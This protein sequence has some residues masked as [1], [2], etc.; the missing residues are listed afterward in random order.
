MIH[1]YSAN[2]NF[3]WY[4]KPFSFRWWIKVFTHYEYPE[5]PFN[6]TFTHVSIGEDITL[7]G[8]RL[9]FESFVVQM[10]N[11]Y[12]EPDLTAHFVSNHNRITDREL[13]WGIVRAE[14]DKPYA[15]LQIID[16]VRI[17]LWNKLFKRDPKN[18][19]FPASSVCSELG[20]TLSYAYA[21]KYSLT[22]LRANLLKYNSNS[23]SPMRLYRILVEA[24]KRGE[25]IFE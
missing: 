10:L 15:F 13:F 4:K 14:H 25:V 7:S 11:E 12:D 6:K 5:I 3:K 23:Y 8:R 19:W 9:I 1:F 18:I 2:T 17:W 22:T 21:K 16:F 20:Y 24:E